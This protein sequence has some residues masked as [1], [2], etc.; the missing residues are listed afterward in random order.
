MQLNVCS[1]RRYRFI[2]SF[3]V[4]S[5][6]NGIFFIYICIV[7]DMGMYGLR[8]FKNSDARIITSWVKSKREFFMWSAGRLGDYP[9]TI[10]S[11]LEISDS[12]SNDTRTFRDEH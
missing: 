2:P 12:L 11:F 3:L 5:C 4:K 10:N 6:K 9:L 1:R 8:P 7:E